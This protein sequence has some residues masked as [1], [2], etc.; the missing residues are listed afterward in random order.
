MENIAVGCTNNT[1]DGVILTDYA[2]SGPESE[3]SSATLIF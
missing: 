2:Y 1:E 3:E